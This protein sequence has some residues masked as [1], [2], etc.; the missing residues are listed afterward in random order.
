[1]KKTRFSTQQQ[2][3]KKLLVNKCPF[4]GSDSEDEDDKNLFK[5]LK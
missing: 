2:V 3:F 5:T 4:E 1:M